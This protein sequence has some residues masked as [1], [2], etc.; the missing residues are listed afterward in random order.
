MLHRFRGIFYCCCHIA[1]TCVYGSDDY[2]P[3]K[4]PPVAS[5]MPVD[6]RHDTAKYCHTLP[7]QSFFANSSEDG[8]GFSAASSLSLVIAPVQRTPRAWSW[9]RLSIYHA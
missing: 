4:A 3:L 7:S 5:L 2:W 6:L 8:I 9:E 1:S